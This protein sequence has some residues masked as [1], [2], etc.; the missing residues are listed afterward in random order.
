MVE[1][2]GEDAITPYYI[3][4]PTGPPQ[5]SSFPIATLMES[6]HWLQQ[7]FAHTLY[8]Q[9]W[10]WLMEIGKNAIQERVFR[11]KDTIKGEEIYMRPEDLQRVIEIIKY[12]SSR[13][14]SIIN[15]KDYEPR[16]PLP[17]LSDFSFVH[18]TLEWTAISGLWQSSWN[19][20]IL[21]NGDFDNL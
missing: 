20:I 19:A 8:Y 7:G 14:P 3:I 5:S 2:E 12:F 9:G 1:F 4:V 13:Y 10:K 16:Y 15:L 17:F 6:L 18:K 11:I 21:L